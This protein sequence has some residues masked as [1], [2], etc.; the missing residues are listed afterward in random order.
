MMGASSEVSHRDVFTR[1]M[2]GGNVTVV[3]L[4]LMNAVFRGS[5]DATIAMRVLWLGNMLNIVLGP[6]FIFGLGP[7][8]ELGVAGAA[9]AT[10]IGRGSAVIYQIV[11]LARGRGRVRIA[12]RHLRLDPR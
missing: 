9:V 4:F 12:R 2:L 11:T 10:N 7:F 1:V 6:C 5:G 8:P 3:L